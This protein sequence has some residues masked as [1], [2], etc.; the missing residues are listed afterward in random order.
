M[1]IYNEEIRDLLVSD[2]NL[3]YEIKMSDSKGSD[4]HVT[5]LKVEEVTSED[6]INN[7]IKR[8]R[9]NRSWAKTLCNE[10]SSRS[11]SVFTLRIEGHNTATTESCS[12]VLN[13]V[14]NFLLNIFHM[15]KY[16]F[17]LGGFGR[18]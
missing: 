13:L 4:L 7:M 18:K 1:E 2:S 17:F 5:N 10:R 3:K 12:G 6:Q 14:R 15:S 8:A 11:H 16:L 9:K